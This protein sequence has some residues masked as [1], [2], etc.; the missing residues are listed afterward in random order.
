MIFT[1]EYWNRELWLEWSHLLLALQWEGAGRKMS[2][3][4][5][6]WDDFRAEWFRAL[7][8]EG[9]KAGFVTYEKR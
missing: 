5:C 4:W 8:D 9:K 6:E 7:F 2:E 1:G 3:E